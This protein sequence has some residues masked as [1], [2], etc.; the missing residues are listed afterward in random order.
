MG[1]L[2]LYAT[3][4]RQSSI[5]TSHRRSI[6]TCHTSS[7]WTSHTNPIRILLSSWQLLIVGNYGPFWNT[8][9][10]CES[11][12]HNPLS[13]QTDR[14]IGGNQES[15]LWDSLNPRSGKGGASNTATTGKLHVYSCLDGEITI[16][17]PPSR[18]VISSHRFIS[19]SARLSPM[20]SPSPAPRYV[21]LPCPDT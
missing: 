12:I 8:S 20:R 19:L 1:A 16:N 11:K 10:F 3:N 6:W 14:I 2:L 21:D 15:R 5:W 17:L 7:T 9:R 18:P 4:Q 13:F